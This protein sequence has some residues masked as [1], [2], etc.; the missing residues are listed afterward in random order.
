MVSWGNITVEFH[1]PVGGKEQLIALI[2]LYFTRKY[3]AVIIIISRL[4][5]IVYYSVLHD[6]EYDLLVTDAVRGGSD[7]GNGNL[8]QVFAALGRGKLNYCGLSYTREHLDSD[9][10]SRREHS[11]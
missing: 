2:K 6:R 1:I 7:R 11:I 3:S 8:I 4:G 5:N 9:T 10:V